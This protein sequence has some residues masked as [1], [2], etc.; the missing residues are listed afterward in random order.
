MQVILKS[1][2]H[3]ELGDIVIAEQLFPIGRSEAPFS[4][5]DQQVV[6][7][8]SRRHARIFME[9]QGIYVADLGSRNGTRLNDKSVQFKPVRLLA[10]DRLTLANQL[11]Y[12]VAIEPG[13]DD[14]DSAAISSLAL[15]LQ[16]AEADS[17]L[18][19]IAINRFPYLIGKADPAF[20]GA[21][22]TGPDRRDYLSRRHAHIY[23]RGDGLYVEDLGSTNGTC[24][25]GERLDEHA[26]PLADGDLLLFGGSYFS[27]RVMLRSPANELVDGDA[28]EAPVSERES[29]TIMVSSADSFLDIFCVEPEEVCESEDEDGGESAAVESS[30]NAPGAGPARPGPLHRIKTFG[31]ELRAAF[32]DDKPGGSRWRWIAVCGL[33]LAGVIALGL[34]YNGKPRRDVEALLAE[35]RFLEAAR[36]STAQLSAQPEDEAL[37]EL[38]TEATVRYMVSTWLEYSGTG[39]FSGAQ[40]SLSEVRPLTSGNPAADSLLDMLAWVTRLQQFIAERGGVLAPI[41]IYQDEEQITELVDWWNLDPEEHRSHM[42]RLLAYVPEFKVIHTEVFSQLRTLRNEQSVYLGAIDK[43]DAIVERHLA[44]DQPAELA[45]EIDS[46]VRQYPRLG[47]AERLQSDLDYYLQV[48]EALRRDDQL[49]AAMLL[50]EAEFS[51]PPFV[52]H[53]Q[54]LQTTLLPSG[55]VARRYSEASAAWRDGELAVALG[56]LE[57]LAAEPAGELAAGELQRKRNIIDDYARLQQYR[58]DPDYGERVLGFYRHLDPAE[59]IHFTQALEQEFQRHST[60]ARAQADLAWQQAASNWGDYREDGGIRG[61]LRLEEDVSARFDRQAGLLSEAYNKAGYASQVYDLLGLDSPAEYVELSQQITAEMA[62]QR[63]SLEQLSMVLSPEIL[64][65]KLRLLASAPMDAQ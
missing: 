52:Q 4:S 57:A 32:G 36:L 59:D 7:H 25:N 46:F 62:L 42:A 1:L 29:H 49:R 58:D 39:D 50:D 19:P 33:A 63:R 9:G 55:K 12:E 5:Y 30:D 21:A 53:A 28:P 16:P 38:A 47:G 44:L 20:S 54:R 48:H 45:Q 65:M 13:S 31:S 18:E 43:L 60:A 3:P 24:L 14:A 61:L 15:N 23:A 41:R 2:S 51:T 34:Y 37:E 6:A 10:G 35:E 26:R 22:V 56:I 64:N 8:L 40:A 17:G 27:Y 11:D